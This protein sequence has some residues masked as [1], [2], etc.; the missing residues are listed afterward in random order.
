MWEQTC[1]PA[2]T[3]GEW[4]VSLCNTGPMLKRR[5]VFFLHDAQTFAIP[6]NFTWQFRLWYRLLFS[7]AG[8][9]SR[10]IMTNSRYSRDELVRRVGLDAG[11]ITPVWLGMEHVLREPPDFTIFE[12]HP[13]PEEH[14]LLAVASASPNK[15][16]KAIL[17]ALELLGNDAPRCVIAGQHN[18]RVFGR[19][20][21][22]TGR[23]THVGR[24]SDAELYALYLRARCLLFPSFYEG[25]GLPPVEAMALG[26]PAIVSRTS[27]MPEICGE[28]AIYCDPADP[29]TLAAAIRR[30]QE[31]PSLHESL[32]ARGRERARLFSWSNGGRLLLDILGR[33]AGKE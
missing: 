13:I 22:D 9:M 4:L 15:N 16:F 20:G 6:E 21:T 33:M 11:R 24:V 26:C 28:A 29:A 10:A 17:Q 32:R 25:F 23:V 3:R 14:Y 27:V 2:A 12:R 31:E 30:L 8:R 19:A 5:Q 7:V 18:P 1:L